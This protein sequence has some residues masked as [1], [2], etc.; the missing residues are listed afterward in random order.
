MSY[1]GN[2]QKIKV[3]LANEYIAAAWLTK[4]N[5]TVY[6]KT[7]DNDVIDLVAVHRITGEVLKI[8]VKTASIRKTWKPGTRICRKLTQEQRRLK[9]KFIFVE[10]DGTCKVRQR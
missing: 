7:Q 1:F 3:G 8:D 5:Y 6:W 4:E 9:M 10:R 2:L